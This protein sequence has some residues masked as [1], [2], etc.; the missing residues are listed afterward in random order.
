MRT[1]PLAL[2]TL[3][4]AACGTTITQ[5]GIN[6]PPHAMPPR[7]V[8]SVEV[9][10]SALPARPHRDVAILEAKQSSGFSL[11]RMPEIIT[12]LRK[13]AAALGCD[14]LVIQGPNNSTQGDRN[15]T[16]TLH[17]FVGTCIAY[18]DG[19]SVAGP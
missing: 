16:Y 3:L 7:P 18:I 10:T 9:V 4:F 2:A 11:D 13:R 19:P 14:G 6:A 15:G 1:S 8:E 5:T 17:G 12:E